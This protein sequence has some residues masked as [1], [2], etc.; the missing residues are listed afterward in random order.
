MYIKKSAHPA[1]MGSNGHS[2]VTG[3]HDKILPSLGKE[4]GRNVFSKVLPTTTHYDFE[5]VGS[6]C[7]FVD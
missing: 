6:I 5:W 7:G 2:D 4:P 3:A 1:V